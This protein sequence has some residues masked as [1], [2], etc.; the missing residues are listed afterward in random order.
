MSNIGGQAAAVTPLIDGREQVHH[1]QPLQHIR[2]RKAL[3]VRVVAGDNAS[4]N[5][6]VL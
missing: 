6:E 3:S 1:N 2:Q 4:N 5:G